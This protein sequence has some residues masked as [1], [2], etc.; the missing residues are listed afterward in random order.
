M[1]VVCRGDFVPA[2]KLESWDRRD[3]GMAKRK[4]K[5]EEIVTVLR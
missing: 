2:D 1:V 5:A 3:P 4:Y